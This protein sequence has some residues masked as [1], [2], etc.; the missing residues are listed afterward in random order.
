MTE[1]TMFR[2][3]ALVLSA[4][5]LSACSWF[6]DD[7]VPVEDRSAREIFDLAESQLA[8]GAPT[9]AA[10]TYDEVE[11]LHPFSQL[12]KRAMINS[13][14]ASYQAGDVGAARASAKRFID[15][16]PS[17][18][19]A[20]YAQYLI[21]LT[22][23]DNIVDV[24]RDQATTT[25]ALRELTEVTRR[26]PQSDYARDAKLKIDLTHNH[27]AGKEMTVGRYYL[28][29]GHYVAAINRFKVVIEKYQ[30]TS[31]TPE[32]LHRIVEAN[33]S[34]GL[35]RPAQTAAAVLGENFPN[36]DWYAA[37]YAL[38]TDRDVR[39]AREEDGFFD[40]VYRRVI[41]GDWL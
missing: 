15:L 10:K 28:K 32:A 25:A 17:D 9:A 21:A 16:Y 7:T 2:W 24:S 31:H 27:L 5:M 8:D 35:T 3:A 34:M 14:F 6:E 4:G 1:K 23:Y 29:R 18:E 26:Y 30:T 12:A 37:S 22:Y 41:R 40:R 36:S 13:A 11:R 33:L 38:L 19:D 20:P 39:P